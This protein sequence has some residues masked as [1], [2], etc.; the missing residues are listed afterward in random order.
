MTIWSIANTTYIGSSVKIISTGYMH[1]ELS[2]ELGQEVPI[3]LFMDA[4][5]V[6]PSIPSLDFWGALFSFML[7]V[8]IPRYH[9][10][11]ITIVE[12]YR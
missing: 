5:D 10:D 6:F 2:L 7:N 3:H 11:L 9:Q 12:S 4:L 8:N 1:G